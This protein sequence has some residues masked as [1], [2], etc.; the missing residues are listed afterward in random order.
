MI[1]T[2]LFNNLNKVALV[3]L[4]TVDETASSTQGETTVL[5]YPICLSLISSTKGMY[6]FLKHQLFQGTTVI[7]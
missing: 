7:Y 5:K 2:W 4:Q 6:S 1:L 3:N